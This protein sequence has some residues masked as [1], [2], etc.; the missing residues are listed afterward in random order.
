[1]TY[2][3]SSHIFELCNF[4]IE[5]LRSFLL[6]HEMIIFMLIHDLKLSLVYILTEKCD[7]TLIQDG[8]ITLADIIPIAL[9]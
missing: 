2:K 4:F 8:S 1:M 9:I 3:V 5:L 6:S 7:N